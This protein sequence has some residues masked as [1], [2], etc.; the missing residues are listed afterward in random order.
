MSS[1]Y[2]LGYNPPKIDFSHIEFDTINEDILNELKLSNINLVEANKK[3]IDTLDAQHLQNHKLSKSNGR[4][5]I[6]NLVLVFLSLI[7]AG[8]SSFYA[9]KQN[10]QSTKQQSEISK[11]YLQIEESQSSQLFLQTQIDSLKAKP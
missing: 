7:P 6:T 11:L 8:F 2:P 4:L 10:L 9:V 3:L 5:S 1:E